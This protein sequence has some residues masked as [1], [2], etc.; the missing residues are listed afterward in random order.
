LVNVRAAICEGEKLGWR[1]GG[2]LGWVKLALTKQRFNTN[3]G[4]YKPALT[5][6]GGENAGGGGG[7]VCQPRS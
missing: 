4:L 7:G 5:Q 6:G 2:L 1:G 3:L